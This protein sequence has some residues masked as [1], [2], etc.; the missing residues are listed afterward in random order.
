MST[1]S[2]HESELRRALQQQSTGVEV[3]TDFAPR[4]IARRRRDHRNRL[5]LVA[6]ACVAAVAVAVPTLWSA[7]RPEL[8]PG[9]ARPTV[10]TSSTRPST[11]AKN[12][13]PPPSS[14]QAAASAPSA[15]SPSSAPS[16]TA[17]VAYAVD[18]VLN[19]G[20]ATITLPQNATVEK[21]ARLQGGAVVVSWQDSGPTRAQLLD[22]AGREL[23]DLGDTRVWV[24]SRDRTR[25]ATWDGRTVTVLDGAGKVLARRDTAMR[26]IDIVVDDV[27]LAGANSAQQW[28]L[29]TGRTSAMPKGLVAVSPSQSRAAIVYTKTPDSLDSCW[30]VVDLTSSRFT[31]SVEKCGNTFVPSAF[32][33]NGTYLVGENASSGGF[34]SGFMIVRADTGAAVFGGTPGSADEGAGWSV[35]LGADERTVWLSANTSTPR[36]PAQANS[37]QQCTIGAGCSGVTPSLKTPRSEPRYVVESPTSD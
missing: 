16:P 10:S 28:N 31:R 11:P 23:A 14:P 35:R 25:F 6:A 24:V 15:S 27:Y 29:A 9:P 19:L 21:F 33:A 8:V 20:P 2:D 32:S 22:G 3:T 13:T 7:N 37:V 36:F 30:A 1:G 18:N 12:T 4:A 17:G 5:A 34:F 26:P